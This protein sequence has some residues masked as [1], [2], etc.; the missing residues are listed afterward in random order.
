MQM[1]VL[2]KKHPLI[3]IGYVSVVDGIHCLLYVSCRIILSCRWSL[4]HQL[5][6]IRGHSI[7][8]AGKLS[9]PLSAETPLTCF[10]LCHKA[11]EYQIT[12]KVSPNLHISSTGR[13]DEKL[14][15]LYNYCFFRSL[16]GFG[17]VASIALMPVTNRAAQLHR[18]FHRS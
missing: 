10:D 11:P 4:Y 14:D 2:D 9:T 16:G 13:P 8:C 15:S 5:R 7:T 3:L 1:I 18:G 12:S 17:D 6:Y